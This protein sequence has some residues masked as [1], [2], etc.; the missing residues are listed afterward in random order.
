M[1]RPLSIIV[2]E[3]SNSD[4]LEVQFQDESEWT[5][6][7]STFFEEGNNTLTQDAFIETFTV[8]KPVERLE[9][10]YEELMEWKKIFSPVV[11][12]TYKTMFVTDGD[13]SFQDNWYNE[14]N[15][16]KYPLYQYKEPEFVSEGKKRGMLGWFI[17]R[18]DEMSLKDY[19]IPK[20]EVIEACKKG[21]YDKVALFLSSKK[22]KKLRAGL[23]FFTSRGESH[24]LIDYKDEK[25]DFTLLHHAVLENQNQISKLL[26]DYEP[27]LMLS[28][29]TKNIWPIHLAAWNGNLEIV[30]MLLLQTLPVLKTKDHVNAV[31]IFNETPLH[32]AVQRG[33]LPVV[34]YLLKKEADPFIRNENKENVLDVASRIGFEKAIRILCKRWP[35]FPVQSSYESLRIGNP[36]IKRAFPAIYPFHLA[37]KYNHVECMQALREHGFAINYTTEDGTAL[38]VASACGQVEAVRFLL[39]IGVNTEIKNQHGQTVLEMIID[40]QENRRPEIAQF[41]KNPEGWK[42]CRSIIEGMDRRDSGRETEGSQ[43]DNERE[44]IWQP[45][46]SQASVQVFP[47]QRKSK[48]DIYKPPSLS[49]RLRDLSPDE[50]PE[51]LNSVRSEG[52]YTSST[53]NR[54]WN[55]SM[56][57]KAPRTGRFPL[58]SPS[59]HSKHYSCQRSSDTLPTKLKSVRSRPMVN[60]SSVLPGDNCAYNSPPQ[61]NEWQQRQLSTRPPAP[62]DNVPNNSIMHVRATSPMASR[63]ASLRRQ[64]GYCTLPKLSAANYSSRVPEHNRPFLNEGYNPEMDRSFDRSLQRNQFSLSRT[65]CDR[66]DSLGLTQ[67]PRLDTRASSVTSSLTYACSTLDKDKYIRDRDNGRAPLA[68]PEEITGSVTGSVIY[69]HGNLNGNGNYEKDNNVTAIF[70]DDMTRPSGENP[71]SPNTSKAFIFDAL[72]G[73]SRLVDSNNADFFSGFSSPSTL[74]NGSNESTSKVQMN[75]GIEAA[76]P[77]RIRRQNGTTNLMLNSLSPTDN[78]SS[79]SSDQ[80]SDTTSEEPSWD[81]VESVFDSFGAA[82]CRESVFEREYGQRVAVYLRD[83]GSKALSVTMFDDEQKDQ[84]SLLA[85]KQPRTVTAWLECDVM[86]APGVAESVGAILQSNGF[87]RIDQL[88][89]TLNKNILT[90]I[91]VDEVTKFKIMSEVEKMSDGVASAGRFFYA[92]EWLNYIGL[93]DY[94]SNFVANGYKHMKKLTEI[95]WDSSKLMQIGVT[96]PGHVARILQSFK[97]AEDEKKKEYTSRIQLRPVMS[98][99]PLPPRM[100]KINNCA[101]CPPGDFEKIKSKLLQGNVVYRAHH[102]GVLEVNET[103]CSDEAHSAMTSIK[104]S[105]S[106]WETIPRVTLDLTCNGITI[107]DETFKTLLDGYGVYTIRVVCQDRKDLNFFC[108]VARDPENRFYCHTFCVL[109]S[110]IASEIITTIGMMFELRSRMDNNLPIDGTIVNDKNDPLDGIPAAVAHFDSL[111]STDTLT[112]NPAGTPTHNDEASSSEKCVI[113]LT[114]LLKMIPGPVKASG[115]LNFSNPVPVSAPISSPAPSPAFAPPP[116]ISNVPLPKS[117]PPVP[118]PVQVPIRLDNDIQLIPNPVHEQY[119]TM[120]LQLAEKIQLSLANPTENPL[121]EEDNKLIADITQLPNP[122]MFTVP[123]CQDWADFVHSFHGNVKVTLDANA[124]SNQ[125][126]RDFFLQLAMFYYVRCFVENNDQSVSGDMH[127]NHIS[128][129]DRMDVITTA[130]VMVLENMYKTQIHQLQNDKMSLQRN[131]TVLTNEKRLKSTGKAFVFPY[132]EFNARSR[133]R[134][135]IDYSMTMYSVTH[136]GTTEIFGFGEGATHAEHINSVIQNM[137]NE[138]RNERGAKLITLSVNAQEITFHT[139]RAVTKVPAKIHFL[140]IAFLAFDSVDK[141]FF[142]I[143]CYLE[144][145]QHL[146]VYVFCTNTMTSTN[147]IVSALVQKAETF[148]PRGM[149]AVQVL[150]GTEL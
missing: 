45:L 115:T 106:D 54:T 139:S 69:G 29:S 132:I 32:L 37:A 85:R 97:K 20:A 58:T 17:W 142:A 100:R 65:T 109:T 103:D 39:E 111:R 107:F 56:Y 30:K 81:R 4:M 34:E 15:E 10:T 70:L 67:S 146:Q 116:Y 98:P 57:D 145:S 121:T 74:S 94:I 41:V 5:Q 117:H 82:P 104:D 50:S 80:K 26:M 89:G 83:R 21:E 128:Y 141:N 23:K 75:S 35:T 51:A 64:P 95:D 63:S 144:K 71:P 7:S 38:H 31:N 87:D 92:S 88:R 147:D 124:K 46:P 12:L 138:S 102:L 8:F 72:Y 61:Y 62:Y 105:I 110:G 14:F 134:Q 73:K 40:L 18:T 91:G 16:F 22:G 44:A 77:V 24:W 48:R 36:D 3:T 47:D 148:R 11:P 127:L 19:V 27:L 131:V 60:I 118:V 52:P 53:I 99:P 122:S 150:I 28:K 93:Q 119:S 43:S 25:S 90:E 49:A 130:V 42:E 143:G 114:S 55:S 140:T 135:P 112:M 137:K 2:E 9:K 13:G 84:K 86:L 113:D 126:K 79:P 68:M 129:T 66:E 76:E 33:H 6:Y 101:E 136:I 123:I 1:K 149:S 125:F 133:D 59:Y 108:F 96:R 78:L 120:Y